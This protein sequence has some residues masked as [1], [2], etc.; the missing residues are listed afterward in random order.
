VA[1]ID[2]Y[3]KVINGA[4][5]VLDNYRPHIPIHPE[6]LVIELG[7]IC[8][9]KNGLNFD[10][11]SSGHTVKII[12]VKDFQNNLFAPLADLDEVQLAAPLTDDYLVKDGDIL[13]VRSNGNPDLVGRSLIV[14]PTTEP[15]TFSGFT[16]RARIED[17]RALPLF[18]AHLFKS[19]DFAE[20]IK[21]VGRGASIRNLSQ[22]ILNEI[23]IPLPPLA[24]QHA[25]VA[26]IEDERALVAASRKLIAHF[27]QKIKATLARFWGEQEPVAT[28]A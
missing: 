15:I 25:I 23:K 5:A 12:G 11:S 7:G 20:M 2:G 1:E 4:S 13:F 8:S 26:E 14:P 17:E 10:K 21:T 19:R 27:E 6:W 24:T 28:E 3:Q 22:A 9:F 16:I 18:Y